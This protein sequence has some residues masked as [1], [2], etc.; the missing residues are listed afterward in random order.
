M[1]F[2]WCGWKGFEW[3]T[4]D[5]VDFAVPVYRRDESGFVDSHLDVG[6]DGLLQVDLR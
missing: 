2:Q 6:W 1:F 4:L 3:V 5:G